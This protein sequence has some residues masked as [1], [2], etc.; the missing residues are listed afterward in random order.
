MSVS[1]RRFPRAA[2]PGLLFL[3]SGCATIPAYIDVQLPAYASGIFVECANTNGALSFQVNRA[4]N[5]VEAADLEWAAK[6]TGDWGIASYTPF[7]STLF[8]IQFTKKTQSYEVTGRRG[9]WLDDV[10]ISTDG[11][12]RYKGQKLGLKPDEFPCF[13]SG[14]LPRGWL[15]QVVSYTTDA[16]GLVLKV[17][18]KDRA[19]SVR[20]ARHGGSTLWNWQSTSTWDVYWG[21]RRETLQLQSRKDQSVILSAENLQDV[22]CRWAPKE[23]E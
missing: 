11:F 16:D 21:L 7:G 13:F 10:T 19:T 20:I 3:G 8:Q 9:D 2:L 17:Q 18:D 5:T 4:G 6:P 15:R 22:E 14:H 12:L 23:E 1:K